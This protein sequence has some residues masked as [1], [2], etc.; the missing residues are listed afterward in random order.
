M[1]NSTQVEKIVD[2]IYRIIGH[3][4]K[5]SILNRFNQNLDLM[6]LHYNTIPDP[7]QKEM[8]KVVDRDKTIEPMIMNLS[9]MEKILEGSNWLKIANSTPVD[10]D[11]FAGL[12]ESETKA[13]DTSKTINNLF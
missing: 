1:F 9:Q 10:F 11:A 12:D 4:S 7:I 8:M 5:T 13:T 6:L 3:D 2:L